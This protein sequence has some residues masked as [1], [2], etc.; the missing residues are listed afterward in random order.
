ML[1]VVTDWAA[2]VPTTNASIATDN[3]TAISLRIED[4][5]MSKRV[6]GGRQALARNAGVYNKLE[7][8]GSTLTDASLEQRVVS[9]ISRQ[10]RHAMPIDHNDVGRRHSQR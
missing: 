10:R 9:A 4:P 8:P 2:D 6:G 5:L 1:E 7:R 3:G